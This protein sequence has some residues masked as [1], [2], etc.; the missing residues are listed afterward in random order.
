[1]AD[2]EKRAG[3]DN[4]Q[5]LIDYNQGFFGVGVWAETFCD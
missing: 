1:M 3:S 2:G 5:G 4:Q